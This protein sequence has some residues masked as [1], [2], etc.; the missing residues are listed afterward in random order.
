[1]RTFADLAT[2]SMGLTNGCFK[3]AQGKRNCLGGCRLLCWDELLGGID[4]EPGQST[5]CQQDRHGNQR[6]V[7]TAE[8]CNKIAERNREQEPADVCNGIGQA[9]DTANILFGDV[10]HDS[11]YD[12]LLR[13]NS[14]QSQPEEEQCGGLVCGQNGG[15][16]EKRSGT[17][18]QESH[19]STAPFEPKSFC[20]G[21]AGEPAT[22][23]SESAEHE[24]KR[25]EQ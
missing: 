10:D 16:R 12:G 20:K 4:S 13:G 25:G 18:A 24:R 11:D 21:I 19:G 7:V 2:I 8:E 9:E 3:L 6:E 5:D 17:K 23:I 15:N 14:S 1:M 22:N